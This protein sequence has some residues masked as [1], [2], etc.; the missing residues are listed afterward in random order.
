MRQPGG[1]G[2][3][4]VNLLGPGSPR[5]SHQAQPPP[6]GPRRVISVHSAWMPRLKQPCSFPQVR[7][8]T[9]A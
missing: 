8:T 4:L 1:P 3:Y 7:G 2:W 6:H 5:N 9:S